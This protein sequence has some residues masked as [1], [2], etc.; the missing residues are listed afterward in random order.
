MYKH[1]TFESRCPLGMPESTKPTKPRPGGSWRSASV[2]SYFAWWFKCPGCKA[3]YLMEAARRS[4][5]AND[6]AESSSTPDF[7]PDLLARERANYALLQGGRE[8]LL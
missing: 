3:I 5:G 2:G 6:A 7:S 4:F 1:A 8:E